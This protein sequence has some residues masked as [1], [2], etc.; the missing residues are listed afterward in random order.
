MLL[1]RLDFKAAHLQPLSE[2]TS[3]F[4]RISV[5]QVSS[6]VQF[7]GQL[8]IDHSQLSIALRLV[9]Q[10]DKLGM[11]LNKDLSYKLDL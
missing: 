10:V 9:Q 5:G 11:R 2:L 6:K 1:A 3:S 8:I 7:V 4:S